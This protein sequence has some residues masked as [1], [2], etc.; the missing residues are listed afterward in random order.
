MDELF[1]QDYSHNLPTL[2][3]SQAEELGID[4]KS[5]AN[6]SK[7][8]LAMRADNDPSLLTGWKKK[9]KGQGKVSNLKYSFKIITMK[10]FSPNLSGYN[11]V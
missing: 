6:M 10:P 11:F 1:F 4:S 8:E 3:Q 5:M 9:G 7:A 2:F